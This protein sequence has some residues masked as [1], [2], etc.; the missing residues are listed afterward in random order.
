MK[1]LPKVST[2]RNKLWQLCR[3]LA[4]KLYP[5]TCYTCGAA[6]LTGSNKQLGHFIPSSTCGAYLRYDMRN[7]RFQCMRCNIHAGGNGAEY[8]RRMV[9]EVGQD[10]VD[11]LFKDKEV[12]TKADRLWYEREIAAK[13][14]LLAR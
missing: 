3:K 11:Q 7:L 14:E 8:Y 5:P 13:K 1:K 4:D 2:V 12:F 6:N 10:A 9:T